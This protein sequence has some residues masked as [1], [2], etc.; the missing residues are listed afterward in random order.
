MTIWQ[1]LLGL[2][3]VVAIATLWGTQVH[4]TA[5]TFDGNICNGSSQ[6]SINLSIDQ[7]YGDIAGQLD[8]VYETRVGNGNTNVS[9]PFLVWWSTN[10]SDLLNVA[11]APGGVGPVGEVAL[12]PLAGF[13][14]TLDSFDLGA[15]PNTLPNTSISSQYTIYD[16]TYNTLISSGPITISRTVHS[17]FLPNLTNANGLIIQWGPDAFNVGIDNIN[18]TVQ[19]INGTVPEPTTWLLL[20]SGLVATWAFHR[21]SRRNA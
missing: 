16:S 20:T 10:Y 1:R 14:V 13:Q 17:H 9:F 15:W 7:T 21:R 5:L 4:A 11:F 19:S 8:V 3:S 18:F 2:L 6:C 12:F